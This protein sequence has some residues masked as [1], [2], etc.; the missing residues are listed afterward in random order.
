[1]ITESKDFIS[2][3]LNRIETHLKDEFCKKIAE[4]TIKKYLE[5]DSFT[6][7]DCASVIANSLGWI[8]E[9]TKDSNSLKIAVE[10]YQ[11]ENILQLVKKYR[12]DVAN[13]ILTNIC[14]V[15]EETLSKEIINKYVLWLGNGHVG[16]LLNL[17]NDFSKYENLKL[18]KDIFTILKVSSN[19]EKF[20]AYMDK[21]NRKK[22]NLERK[23]ELFGILKD[24]LELGEENYAEILITRGWKDLA[25]VIEND[26]GIKL[27]REISSIKYGIKI[28][29]DMKNDSNIS[30]LI[31]KYKEFN[32]IK[33]WLVENETTKSVIEKI[34]DHGFDAELYVASRKKI[35]ETKADG[36]FSKD[37]KEILKMVVMKLIGSKKN[38]ILPKISIK[39]ISPGSIFKR[40]KE[41]Y[42]L[43][44]KE[45]KDAGKKV[46]LELKNIISKIYENKKVPQCVIKI[47][48]DIECLEKVIDYGGVTSYRG[49]KIIAKVWKR[50]IPEDF[51]DSERLRCC[52]FLPSGEKKNEIPLLIMDP[53]TTLVQ[54]YIQDISEPVAAATFYAGTSENKSVLLM[55]TWEAGGLAYAALPNAKMHNFVLKAMI[56]FARKVG[57]KKLLIFAGAEYGRPEEFCL[58]LKDC[59]YNTEK[60]YFEAVDSEDTVIKSFSSGEKHHY[61][62]AF[63]L[64]PLKG[65]I[66]AFVFDL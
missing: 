55:D 52:M 15:M 21:I 60:V 26:L 33:K 9:L 31:Q 32:T 38:K 65:N 40:I 56:K 3:N 16:K 13:E 59:E 20:D 61:T 58:Y 25:I 53:Q 49:A 30:F 50:K 48:N 36:S 8:A 54:F 2:V 37:W 27:P 47:L 17:A 34:K 35:A 12:E 63:C 46:L 4:E 18:K 24:I 57:A 41:N 1:M 42:F 11:M 7:A 62:D 39:N 43:A 64:G 5:I 23:V 14:W 22:Y 51:Y 44:L 19:Q 66:E 29:R 45:D 28:L 6:N 10:C